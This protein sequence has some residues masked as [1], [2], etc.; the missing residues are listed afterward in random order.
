MDDRKADQ[1]MRKN[2]RTVLVI[3]LLAALVLAVWGVAARLHE[4]SQLA[5]RTNNDAE[6]TVVIAKPQMSGAGDELVL[7]G[8]VQAFIEAPIYARTSGYLKAWHADIGSH[9]HAGD[10]LAEI[11]TPEVDRQLSQA[12]ADLA[13]AQANLDLSRSTNERWKELLKTQSVSKQDADEKA[14]DAAAK[15]ATT[16]SAAQNVHRLQEL[17]GF[18]RVLAPFNGVVTA[19]N[20]DVGDLINAGQSSG[21]ELFRM[22]DT[23]RLRIYAQV[24]EAY[25][26]ATTTGLQAELHFAEYP[27]KAWTAE[28]VRTSNALDPTA[29]TL[30]VELQ[31]DNGKGELFPGAYAEVHFKLPESMQTM[32]LPAN[33]ILFRDGLQVATVDHDHKIKLK[34]VTQGRD[35]GKTVEILAGIDRDDSVV[36]NPPD[37][38][39]DGVPVRIAPPPPPKTQDPGK[40]P[41]QNKS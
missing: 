20:T 33:V 38:I 40:P 30:Q 2:I 5:E 34:S 41:A 12:K 28:T 24:P 7:P 36:V 22:A 23:H 1:K 14:G 16:E 26:V 29:R 17:E 3:L 6:M 25:A 10:L 11:E 35:F 18:K 39:E 4:R 19:R 9:V 21:T 27:G 8:I 13:T 15:E 37:S 32:R 31:L